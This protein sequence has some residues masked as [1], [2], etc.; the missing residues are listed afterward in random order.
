[1]SEKTIIFPQCFNDFRVKN[2]F[3]Y[4]FVSIIIALYG[5]AT[6]SIVSSPVIYKSYS[7]NANEQEQRFI[8]ISTN[9]VSQAR[10][11]EENIG[12]NKLPVSGFK[13]ADI[14]AWVDDKVSGHLIN[15]AYSQYFFYSWVLLVQ[16]KKTEL[17]Y[18]FHY[19]W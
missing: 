4:L 6:T 13:K 5:Y 19:F 9:L 16:I 2:I 7:N 12:L 14:L 10:Q 15:A 11:S 18:P 1:M 17:I 8:C 3:K